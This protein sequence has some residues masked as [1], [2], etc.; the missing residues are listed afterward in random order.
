MRTWLR[1]LACLLQQS[2]H[3][4][5]LCEEIETHRAMRAAQ[6]K[7]EGLTTQEAAAASPR[8]IGNV[9]LAVKM[10]ATSGSDRSI[11]GRTTSATVCAACARIRPSPRL[12]W[13]RLRSASVSTPLSEAD[14]SCRRSTRCSSSASPRIRM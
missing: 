13:R 8:A 11:A 10:H 6:L 1:R 4:A 9:L 3:E 2:R 12:R 7:R 14:M 5:E